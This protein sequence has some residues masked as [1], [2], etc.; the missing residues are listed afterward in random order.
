MI[1][2]RRWTGGRCELPAEVGP[3]R[4]SFDSWYHD[5]TMRKCLPFTYGGCRGN[6]NRFETEYQCTRACVIGRDRARDLRTST[7]QT[8]YHQP[9]AGR[10]R[11][12]VFS[13]STTTAAAPTSEVEA[14]VRSPTNMAAAKIATVDFNKMTSLDRPLAAMFAGQIC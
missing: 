1:S 6:A 13:E 3:C 11:E 12:C 5:T 2:G 9:T 14:V 8:W 7:T 4:G 10:H